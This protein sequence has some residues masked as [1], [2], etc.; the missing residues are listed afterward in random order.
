MIKRTK[1]YPSFRLLLTLISE[2]LV[3]DP[4]MRLDVSGAINHDFFTKSKGMKDF[5]EGF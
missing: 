5:E 3:P 1:E 2:M 4:F